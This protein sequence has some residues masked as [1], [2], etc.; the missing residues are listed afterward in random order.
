MPRRNP[1]PACNSCCA[2]AVPSDVRRNLIGSTLSSWKPLKHSSF[3]SSAS[4]CARTGLIDGLLVEDRTLVELI[5][6]RLEREIAATRR[7]DALEIG[8]RVL[9]REATGA[10]VDAVRRELERASAEAEHAFAERARKIAESLEKQFERFL[11]EDGGAMSKVLDAHADELAEL[12]ARH[13]GGDRN[14][15][16]QHQL[17][18]L[19]AKLLSASRGRI[20]CASSRPRT[21]TTRSP[22]SRRRWFAR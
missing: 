22:T 19:V 4:S 17:K 5:E 18:E 10:E 16:V 14:T 9:D 15:A 3:T 11:G 2:A 7:S 6:R 21:G 20:C 8:A 12:V 13:F 1:L